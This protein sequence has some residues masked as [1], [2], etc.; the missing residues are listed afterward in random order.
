MDKLDTLW[1]VD[2]NLE[3][4]TAYEKFEQFKRA[5]ETNNVNNEYFVTFERLNNRL[6]DRDK[7]TGRGSGV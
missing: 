6:I 1:K 2:E 3:A 7:F 5:Q 4:F